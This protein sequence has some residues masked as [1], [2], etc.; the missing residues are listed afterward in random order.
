MPGDKSGSRRILVVED[1]VMICMMIEDLLADAGYQPV[2]PA[3]S[4]D[5][6]LALV[7]AGGFDAVLLDLGLAGEPAYPIAEAL[8]AR[9]LPFAFLTGADGSAL[10]ARF[11]DR[12]VLQKPFEPSDLESTLES[13]LAA[14][15]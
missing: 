9:A 1:E 13:L 3:T 12:P 5:E 2:G 14:A 15:R 4:L 6:G 7:E 8:S 11:S 10:D